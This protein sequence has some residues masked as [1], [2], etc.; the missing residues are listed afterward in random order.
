MQPPASSLLS[1]RLFKHLGRQL[2]SPPLL[3]AI[4]VIIT[5]VNHKPRPP[6]TQ[7]EGGQLAWGCNL[8]E[9]KRDEDVHA[10][11]TRSKSDNKRS[12]H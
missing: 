12:K 4:T 11:E 6:Q 2:A 7:P 8:R 1:C 10:G 9:E 5:P 3:A